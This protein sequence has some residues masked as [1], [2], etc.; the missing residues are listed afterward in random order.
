MSE[1]QDSQK[2]QQPLWERIAVFVS[3]F[4]LISS[5][6]WIALLVPNPTDFRYTIFRIVLALSGAAFAALIPGAVDIKYR[7]Y[8]RAGG[9]MAVL[10]IIYFFT[11]AGTTSATSGQPISI[12]GDCNVIGTSG[13]IDC[14]NS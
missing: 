11:V 2:Y 5:M 13:S 1:V 4:V 7:S 10:I 12:N 14:N 6:V 8:V 3:G 9:A